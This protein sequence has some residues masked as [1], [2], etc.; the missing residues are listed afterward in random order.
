[1]PTKVV[2]KIITESRVR[3][4]AEAHLLAGPSLKCWHEISRAAN[5]TSFQDIKKSWKSADYVKVGSGRPVVVFNIAGNNFRLIAA[6]HFNTGKVYVLR[7]YTHAE[8]D[9]NSWK[10]EL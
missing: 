7:F 9:R 2:M 6:V 1:V 3:G 5:W 8:Y 4:W 10:K